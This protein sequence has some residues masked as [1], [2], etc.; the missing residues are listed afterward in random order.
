MDVPAR[1]G[2]AARR[3]AGKRFVNHGCVRAAQCAAAGGAFYP[4]VAEGGWWQLLTSAF[5]HVDVLHIGFNMVALWFLG[6]QLERYFGRGRYLAL[7]L[8]SG[9][10]GSVA[11]YW[12]T[13]TGTSTLGASGAVFGLLGALLVVVWRIGGDWRNVLV[14]LGINVAFT[15]FGGSGI[16]WQGHLGGLAGGILIA[17]ILTQRRGRATPW[18]L[19]AGLAV[20]LVALTVLRTVLLV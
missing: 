6:P 18:P 11:V 7:Y 19:L 2:N 20:V 8:L 16:S 5:T 14:W 13:G 15:F 3:A 12:L 4:G 17:L 1:H 10:A 9:L